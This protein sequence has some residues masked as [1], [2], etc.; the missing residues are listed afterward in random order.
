M[1]KILIGAALAG[2]IVGTFTSLSFAA[3]LPARLDNGNPANI[4][5]V[6]A[7][8]GPYHHFIHGFHDRFGRWF[9]GHCIR[10]FARDRDYDHRDRY[11]HYYRDPY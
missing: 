3:P 1:T 11:D 10:N 7:R 5:Q 9:P 6:D 2:M 4:V 8:C